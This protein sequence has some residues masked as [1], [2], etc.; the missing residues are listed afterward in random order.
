VN[1]SEWASR[2]SQAQLR[3][4]SWVRF[5]PIADI[6]LLS[7]AGGMRSDLD[8]RKAEM[9]RLDFGAVSSMFV[10]ERGTQWHKRILS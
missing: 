2:N 8:G 10:H 3:A 1:D 5:P 4:T 9:L 7:E 6:P